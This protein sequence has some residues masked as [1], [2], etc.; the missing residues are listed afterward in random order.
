MK[1]LQILLIGIF[2][3]GFSSLG[4]H[5]QVFKDIPFNSPHL[6]NKSSFS[7]KKEDKKIYIDS[8]RL[9]FS[10][11]GIFLL[12]THNNEWR[13]IRH[14]HHD[15]QGYYLAFN[16]A[17]IVN[18]RKTGYNSTNNVWECPYCG[19]ENTSTNG[20]CETCLWPLYHSTD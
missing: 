6:H 17:T 5:N 2:A 15:S 9:H 3:A 10:N 1:I 7:S 8:D 18:A 14:I 13:K 16:R 12:T 4:A 20:V 11:E 19:A